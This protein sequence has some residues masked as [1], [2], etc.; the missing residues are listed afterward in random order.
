MFIKMAECSLCERQGYF[1]VGGSRTYGG[2]LVQVQLQTTVTASLVSKRKTRGITS[3]DYGQLASM[4]C[5][6]WR[7]AEHT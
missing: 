4:H 2:R 1:V 7:N 5:V 3:G 6:Y